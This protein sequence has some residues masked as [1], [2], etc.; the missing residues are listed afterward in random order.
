M[1]LDDI[2]INC[3]RFVIGNRKFIFERFS[4]FINKEEITPQIFMKIIGVCSGRFQHLLTSTHPFSST[5]T[6][7]RRIELEIIV[8][9]VFDIPLR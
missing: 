1:K 4:S 8:P 5:T 2:I 9:V 7:G 6:R 3:I